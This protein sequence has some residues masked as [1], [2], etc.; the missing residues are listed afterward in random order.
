MLIGCVNDDNQTENVQINT[1]VQ[2]EL[3]YANL[4]E[5]DYVHVVEFESWEAVKNI[6]DPVIFFEDSFE[7]ITFSG[8]LEFTA[9]YL[10]DEG[11][12]VDVHYTGVLKK[13]N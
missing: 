4:D 7:G 6:K 2:E 3:D 13:V 8:N 10:Q 9:A 1:E 12:K 11:P 5:I